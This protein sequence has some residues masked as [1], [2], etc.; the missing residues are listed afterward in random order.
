MALSKVAFD[1]ENNTRAIHFKKGSPTEG[2]KYLQFV[3][4]FPHHVV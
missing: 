1:L 4:L 3:D 2:K